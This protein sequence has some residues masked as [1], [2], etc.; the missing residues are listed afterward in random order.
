MDSTDVPGGTSEPWDNAQPGPRGP[1][2]EYLASPLPAP[3]ITP[4]P[5]AALPPPSR[6]PLALRRPVVTSFRMLRS[7]SAGAAWSLPSPPEPWCSSVSV[8]TRPTRRS[9]GAGPSRR[10]LCL[11]RRSPCSRWTSTPRPARR[12]TRSSCCGSSPPRRSAARTRT[13]A[14]GWCA[15]CRPPR[16]T[17]RSTSRRTSSPGWARGSRSAAVPEQRT[18]RRR[19]AC[20]SSRT[21]TTRRPRPGWTR[22][23][24][25]IPARQSSTTRSRTATWSSHRTR[26]ER[27]SGSST[28]PRAAPLSA[29][30]DLH[31][32]HRLAGVRP[33]RHGLGRRRPARSAAQQGRR[34]ERRVPRRSPTRW[35]RPTRV[36][37]VLGMHVTSSSVVVQVKTRGG[38]PSTPATLGPITNVVKDPWAVV[39][40]SG[41]SASIDTSGRRSPRSPA[42]RTCSARPSVSTASRCPVT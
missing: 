14:T 25:Q 42:T 19:R 1:E 30:L 4:A 24:R 29:R 21:P 41:L 38:K 5:F 39:A 16:R 32:G 17:P 7:A 20:S 33:D 13:S 40:V 35:R 9:T 34:E 22:S 6:Q 23:R 10:W 18:R 2:Y 3:D 31:L 37:Y 12:S 15:G 27:P 26:R 8:A 11:P 28:P 36:R